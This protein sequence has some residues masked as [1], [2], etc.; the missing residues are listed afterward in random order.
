MK[1]ETFPDQAKLN[2]EAYMAPGYMWPNT[3]PYAV[4]AEGALDVN[5]CKRIMAWAP[6]F[7]PYSH[8]G[9]D[10]ITRE[11]G[12]LDYNEPLA[13]LHGTMTREVNDKYFD[14]DLRDSM[15]WHQSY[16][17]GNSY[18]EHADMSPG[19]GRKLTAIVMLS[20][21]DEY[22]GGDLTINFPPVLHTLPRTRGTVIWIQPWLL[23]KVWPVRNGHRETINMGFFGPP[24][25]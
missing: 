19:R 20:D 10:A 12:P 5:D 9:C 3:V 24:F 1:F 25:K 11:I 17:P 16:G 18:Q 7:E 4:W 2:L 23:H 22:E 8:P 6:Q 15:V 14:Y 21:P 13:R